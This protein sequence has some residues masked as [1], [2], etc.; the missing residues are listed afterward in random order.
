MDKKETVKIGYN[1]AADKLLK[2]YQSK[3]YEGDEMV[4]LKEFSSKIPINGKVLDAGCGPGIP[5]TRYLSQKFQVTGVD[6][7]DKQIELA[8][9]NVPKAD[10]YCEDITNLSFYDEYFDGIVCYYAIIHVPREEHACVLQNFYRMLRKTG[11]ILINF[12]RFDDPESY[13]E[14]FFGTGAKMYWSGFDKATNEKLIQKT[15]FN[16]R[17]SKLVKE[18]S[19]WGDSYHL[20]VFAEK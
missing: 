5:Y 17:W 6:I 4:L 1:K 2:N 9:K 18:P 15:G 10:F 14:D 8:K 12:H 11:V 7:S 13:A 19:K 20:F 3:G 16:I